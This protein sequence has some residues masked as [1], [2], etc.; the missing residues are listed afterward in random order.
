MSA[1]IRGLRRLFCDTSFFYSSLDAR[2]TFHERAKVLAMEAAEGQTI[3]SSTWD[4]ISETVTLLRYRRN[5]QLAI[6]FLDEF[7]PTLDIVV[8]GQNVYA[9]AEQLFRR[10]GA[11]RR[12]SFCDAISFVVIT[13]MLD[14]IPCLSFDQDFRALGLTVLS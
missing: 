14:N 8:Y 5:Y 13:T 6:R 9:A 2:D 7:K 10:Y 4:V 12:L 1:G 3:L 11:E